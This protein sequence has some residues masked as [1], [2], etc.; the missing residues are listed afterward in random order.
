MS[1]AVSIVSFNTKE[2]LKKCLENLYSQKGILDLEIWVVDNASEDGSAEMVEKEFKRVNL[3]R[4][5]E[6]LGFAKGQNLAIRKIS[7]DYV[8]LLNPDTGLPGDALTQMVEF[9]DKN[10]E[11]G[12]SSCKIVSYDGVMQSNGGDLPFGI[13]LISWLFN[14]EI[15]GN[16]PNYHRSDSSFYKSN[17]NIGWVGGTF[18]MVRNDVFKNAGLLNEDFFMYF[19]DVEFC[20]RTH[21]KGY[22]IR[23]NPEV[24]IKHISG[25]SSTN[26]TL[27]QC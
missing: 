15:L 2:L 13:A 14:L 4:S 8:L 9:M 25:A 24:E 10:P 6:N 18:M 5:K 1:L 19:E 22:K 12:I 3:I 21:K 26:P 7:D 23:I 16:L 11:C 20:Y 17:K 27:R